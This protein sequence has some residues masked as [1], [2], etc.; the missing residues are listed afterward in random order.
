M[1]DETST[2]VEA[3]PETVDRHPDYEMLSKDDREELDKLTEQTQEMQNEVDKW[4]A[5]MG[6]SVFFLARLS[7]HQELQIKT[8]RR[9]NR[10]LLR[11]VRALED[12]I[13]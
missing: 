12:S 4:C 3:T 2:P 1:S 9:E 13:S 7:L 6:G 5:I 11:R 10:E 8:L